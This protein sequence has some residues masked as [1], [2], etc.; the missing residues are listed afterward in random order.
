[1]PALCTKDDCAGKR[2][3][4]GMV[5]WHARVLRILP[6]MHEPHAILRMLL[7]NL[8]FKTLH[9]LTAIT[10]CRP[11]KPHALSRNPNE[12]KPW[13]ITLTNLKLHLLKDIFPRSEFPIFVYGF[14]CPIEFLPQRLGEELFNRYVKFLGEDHRKTRINIILRASVSTT[15]DIL[16]RNHSQS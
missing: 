1:M 9:S 5:Q 3:T 7:R 2:E 14:D 15:P 6:C 11:P 8:P 10:P 16:P 12:A 13:N 4:I